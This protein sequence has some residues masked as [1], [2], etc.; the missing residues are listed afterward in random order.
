MYGG[1]F[2]G[3]INPYIWRQLKSAEIHGP[4]ISPEADCSEEKSWAKQTTSEKLL[5]AVPMNPAAHS[6][7]FDYCRRHA[8]VL[9]R[10]GEAYCQHTHLTDTLRA[11]SGKSS[12]ASVAT[13][14]G[15]REG[16]HV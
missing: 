6:I 10:A 3:G 15:K 5:V 7:M 1:K 2:G 14:T 16:G 11:T 4:L 9:A 8:K 13:Q 12:A